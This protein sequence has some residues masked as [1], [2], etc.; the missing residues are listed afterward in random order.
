MT[1]SLK[2]HASPAGL[3]LIKAFEGICDG[4]PTTVNL[5]P[6]LDPVKIWSIGWGHAIRLNGRFLKDAA[7][8]ALAKSLFPSGITFAEAEALLVEDVAVVAIYLNAVFPWLTQNQ[9]DAL[10][11]FA[12]NVG[13]GKFENSTL[14]KKLKAGDIAGAAR[15][16]GRW[17]HG[18]DK[19]G[20]KI[21]LPGLV[22]RRA[23]ERKLFLTP[24]VPDAHS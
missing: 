10:L 21:E 16:F 20:N 22:T 5:D 4:D 11:S 24:E 15:E 8:A 9:F 1:S 13:I 12:F 17:I 2:K 14:F 23:E 7:D 3:A 19:R 18:T 6:Y